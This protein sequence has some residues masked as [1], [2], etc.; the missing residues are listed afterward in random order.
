MVGFLINIFEPGHINDFKIEI[1][2]KRKRLILN[3]QQITITFGIVL[4]P[5]SKV[6]EI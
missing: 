5:L 4:R 1:D 3:R 2:N 6:A